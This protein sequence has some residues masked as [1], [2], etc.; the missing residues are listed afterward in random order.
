M[1]TEFH[2]EGNG[3]S[4]R[5]LQSQKG[6]AIK[7]CSVK[8]RV[9]SVKLCVEL[10]ATYRDPYFCMECG[11]ETTDTAFEAVQ[12]PVQE[13]RTTHSPGGFLRQFGAVI[14]VC[15]GLALLAQALVAIVGVY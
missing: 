15:L 11:V 3:A 6:S 7:I 8:L 5:A 12:A 2:R 13:S 1:H 9:H 4:R 14:A 10:I